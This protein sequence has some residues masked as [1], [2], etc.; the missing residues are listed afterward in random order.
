MTNEEIEKYYYDNSG[1]WEMDPE[2]KPNALTK[3]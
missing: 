2:I 3:D 1:P